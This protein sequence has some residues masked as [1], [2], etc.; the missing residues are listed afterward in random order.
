MLNV[1]GFTLIFSHIQ[2]LVFLHDVQQRVDCRK[3][4]RSARGIQLCT[5]PSR[6]SHD[7]HGVYEQRDCQKDQLRDYEHKVKV[8]V[9]TWER[10]H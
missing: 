4:R 3:Y 2:G 7:Y 1:I 9:C 8:T 10:K 5:G 6:C